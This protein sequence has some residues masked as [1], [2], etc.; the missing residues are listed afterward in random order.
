MSFMKNQL[1]PRS[2]FAE[3][4]GDRDAPQLSGRVQFQQKAN[5]VLVT[6]TVRGLPKQNRSGFFG[7]HIHQGTSCKGEDFPETKGHLNPDRKPHPMHDG[8]L[9]PLLSNQGFAYMQVFT[10]RFTVGEII[11]KTIVIHAEHDDFESQPG[12]DAGEKIG[13]G[14]IRPARRM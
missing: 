9:P 10:D 7:F 13:C 12:G 6:A 8:D 2:A 11:G 3:I 1:M 4:R 14:E 5:G